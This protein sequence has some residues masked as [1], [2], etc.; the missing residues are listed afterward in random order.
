LSLPLLNIGKSVWVSAMV[1]QAV[2]RAALAANLKRHRHYEL[3]N[4]MALSDSTRRQVYEV[5]KE[6]MAMVMEYKETDA[7]GWRPRFS[8]LWTHPLGIA[9]SGDPRSLS[10]WIVSD[11]TQLLQHQGAPLGTVILTNRELRWHGS[12]IYSGHSERE[13]YPTI[14]ALGCADLIYVLGPYGTD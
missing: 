9:G 8:S 10:Y 13:V 2:D 4:E 14:Q 3:S 1:Q 7:S 6:A 12:G 11:I 5:N